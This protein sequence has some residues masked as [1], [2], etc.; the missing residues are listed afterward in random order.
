MRG[1]YVVDIAGVG[2][3]SLLAARQTSSSRGKS[4]R[5]AEPSAGLTTPLSGPKMWPAYLLDKMTNAPLIAVLAVRRY[6]AGANH[7]EQRELQEQLADIA[8]HAGS[9]AWPCFDEDEALRLEGRLSAQARQVFRSVCRVAARLQGGSTARSWLDRDSRP[10]RVK[11]VATPTP[12]SRVNT[13]PSALHNEVGLLGRFLDTQPPEFCRG[14]A[15]VLRR[16]RKQLEVRWPDS[17][18]LEWSMVAPRYTPYVSQFA[19]VGE[20]SYSTR[21]LAIVGAF[22]GF[23]LSE[24][25]DA[26]RR[27]WAALGLS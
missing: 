6:L 15:A 26:Q 21:P 11:E 20:A 23:V 12:R 18:R 5:G 4:C 1:P 2:Y 10:S 8:K 9:E 16:W 17:Q 24:C 3:W 14:Y 19:N 7:G 25:P 27:T 22:L 13:P